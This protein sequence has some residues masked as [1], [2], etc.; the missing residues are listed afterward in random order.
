MIPVKKK[1]KYSKF[2]VAAER[3]IETIDN[4]KAVLEEIIRD[5]AASKGTNSFGPC[6]PRKRRDPPIETEWD[7]AYRKHLD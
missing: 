6:G 4:L 3:L 2:C 1:R 5:E 7:R